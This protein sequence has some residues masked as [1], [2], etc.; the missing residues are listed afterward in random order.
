FGDADDAL[1]ALSFRVQRLGSYA[2]W[3]DRVGRRVAAPVG[4]DLCQPRAVEVIA[5]INEAV[6][7]ATEVDRATHHEVGLH[8][9]ILRQFAL[10]AN[11]RVCGVTGHGVRIID[12]AEAGVTRGLEAFDTA[13]RKVLAVANEAEQAVTYCRQLTQ[14]NR[15]GQRRVLQAA[16]G[17][18]KGRAGDDVTAIARRSGIGALDQ[19]RPE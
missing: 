6:V 2:E 5:V 17:R 15:A 8:N 11:A 14:D 3:D 10:Y 1:R 12:T 7:Q 16:I 13:H 9:Q 19:S 4:A 18:A